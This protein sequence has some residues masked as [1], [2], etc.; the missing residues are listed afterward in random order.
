MRSTYHCTGYIRILLFLV[1]FQLLSSDSTFAQNIIRGKITGKDGVALPGA[2]VSVK[3]QNISTTADSSGRYALVANP[4]SIL[5][6]SFIGYRNRQIDIGSET[7]LNISLFESLVNLD[8][9]M[10]VGYGTSKRKDITGAVSKIISKDFNSGIV[11]SPLQQIQGKVAGLVIVQP[12]GDPNGDFSVRIRGATSLEGQP[13]LLVIDGVAIDDFNKALTTLNPSD[14]ESYDI[15]KD[16]SASAIYGSR[17]ANGV[18]LVTT[19]RSR[20]GRTMVDYSGFTG[21]EMVSKTLDV[22]NADQYLK[23]AGSGGLAFDKGA[24]TDWQKAI[25]RTALSQSHMIGLSGG[26][27]HFNFRGSVGYI[28]QDGIVL[29]NSKEVITARLTVDQKSF[30]DKL[31][32]RYGI[33]TSV[34]NRNFLSDQS[35]TSQVHQSGSG[36]FYAALHSLPVIPVYNPDGSYAGYFGDIPGGPVYDLKE[37]YSKQRENFFQTSLKA[38]YTLIRDF[39]IGV[40]GALTRG[41]DVYDYFRPGIPAFNVKS[42]ASKANN[43]KQIFTGDLHANYRKAVDKHVLDLTGVY[44]YNQFVNDGFAVKARGF[45]V[46]DLLNNNLGAATN[47]QLG[48]VS[49][50]KNEVVL[51]SILGRAVYSYDNRYIVTASF[52]RDGSSKFGSNNRWGNFPSVAFAWRASNE[53]FLAKIKWLNNLKLRVSYG[54]TGNQENLA[55]YPYQLLY[56]PISPALY[57]GQIVQGYG[58]VQ[59]NNPDLKWEVRKS[60]NVGLDFSVFDNRINGTVDLFTD[61]TSDMLFTYDLPQPP[62]LFDKVIANAANAINKGIEITLSAAIVRKK[63]FNWDVNFN[64]G[65]L[66]NRITNL[67][68]QFN[69]ANLNLTSEQQ[70]YGYADGSGFSG[71]YI[72]QLQ[73]GY[74]AGVF[75]LPQHAGLDSNG[76]EL[77]NNYDAQGKLIGTDYG[78]SDKDRVYIDPTPKFTWGLTNSFTFRNIDLSFLLR[79]VKG[80]KVFANAQ[81]TQDAKVYLP[82]NNVGVAALTNGFTEQPQPSTYWLNEASFTRLEFLTVGYNFSEVKSISKLRLYLSATNVFVFT[83]YKGIDPEIKTEGT[84]RFIDQNHYPKTRGFLIGVNVAF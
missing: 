16:A 49:S 32:M 46:P 34:I 3:G 45:L 67:S 19:K 27:D 79:G 62:F 21:M 47:I 69:G 55:P 48:D 44:E 53:K 28:K 78:Y 54:L 24:N 80:Q 7:D 75:W 52:R 65:T 23:A 77:F 13:P 35:S 18:I 41:N 25:T 59:E 5:Q 31:E 63:N 9:V 14:V 40:L 38:D 1:S 43:N 4:G 66:R 51:K 30:N 15:L 29:N 73:K 22:L 61:K 84:Q 17:G 6:V 36:I 26:T 20:A 60:F 11:T 39:K 83:P 50:Y 42:E 37:T 64:L 58:V 74:P 71:A 10:L 2:T 8:E 70:H 56:G 33:N 72:T 76:R 12:S 57:Y 82:F 68:G 81:L